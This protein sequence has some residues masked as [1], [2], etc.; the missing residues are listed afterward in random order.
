M[1]VAPPVLAGAFQLIVARALPAVAVTLCGGLGVVRGV[2]LADAVLGMLGP[3]PFVAMT[4]NVYGVPFVRS[5]TVQPSVPV[6]QVQVCPP[7]SAVAV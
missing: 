2:M 7:G 3:V 5:V 6:V 1:I 4:V